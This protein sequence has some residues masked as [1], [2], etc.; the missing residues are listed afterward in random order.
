MY[1]QRV[2]PAVLFAVAVSALLGGVLG[3]RAQATSDP[4]TERYRTFTAALAAGER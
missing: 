4:V 3:R 2:L 1:K